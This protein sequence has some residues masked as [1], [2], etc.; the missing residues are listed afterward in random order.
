MGSRKI[1][2]FFYSLIASIYM[3]IRLEEIKKKKKKK[4]TFSNCHIDV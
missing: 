2:G 4:K 1:V 3:A